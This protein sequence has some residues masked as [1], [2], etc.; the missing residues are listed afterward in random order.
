MR[1]LVVVL[2]LLVLGGAL[3][4][5]ELGAWESRGDAFAQ[6]GRWE[7]AQLA[8]ETALASDPDNARLLQKY[9]R[10]FLQV[11]ASGRVDDEE[12]RKVVEPLGPKGISRMGALP[13]PAPPAPAAGEQG[14]P[15]ATPEEPAQAPAAGAGAG[16]E[17][18]EPAGEEAGTSTGPGAQGHSGRTAGPPP[19]R[20]RKDGTIEIRPG[21]VS[22]M[23]GG[24]TGEG[25]SEDEEA[26]G[27]VRYGGAQTVNVD[28]VRTGYEGSDGAV[29][30]ENTVIQTTKYEI[31]HVKVAYRGKDLHITGKLKNISDQL[32][33]LPR[34]YCT[35]YDDQ[36]VL[37]GRSYSYI[38]PGRNILNKGNTRNFDVIF[39][40]YTEQV[41]SYR[42]EVIP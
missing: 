10:A 35:I 34:V 21:R 4:A 37:R 26:K 30:E 28:Q 19:I 41:A 11:Y 16:E 12:G 17:D 23:G 38:S 29:A 8:Y 36:S 27:P 32:V 24:A 20:I 22:R 14:A 6:A 2:G 18:P 31:S 25:E 5:Q 15:P 9:Q 42:F 3:G 33:K 7:R 1:A 40:G 39:R 13:A